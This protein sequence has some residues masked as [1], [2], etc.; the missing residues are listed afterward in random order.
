MAD[1]VNVLKKIH[2]NCKKLKTCSK[3][4]EFQDNEPRPVAVE[5]IA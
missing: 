4:Q 2:N 5:S 3:F 1:A